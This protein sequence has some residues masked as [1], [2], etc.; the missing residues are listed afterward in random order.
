M[1]TWHPREQSSLGYVN[2]AVVTK[3]CIADIKCPRFCNEIRVRAFRQVRI[4]IEKN[5]MSDTECE[6]ISKIFFDRTEQLLLL[7][8]DT[9]LRS[10]FFL[11]LLSNL[12]YCTNTT[13]SYIHLQ[14]KKPEVLPLTHEIHITD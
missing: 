1:K 13:T 5:K 6:R 11:F 14:P 7:L 10:Y 2:R 12:A 3:M 9:T 8:R 4:I